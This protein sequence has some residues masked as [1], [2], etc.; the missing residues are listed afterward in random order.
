LKRIIPAGI[1]LVVLIAASV[2][3]AANTYTAQVQFSPNK[4]GT[5]KAPAAIGFTMNFKAGSSDA[6]R[7]AP[8]SDVTA[9]LYGLVSNG[10]DFPICTLN[11]IATAKSDTGCKKGS[12]VATGAITSVLGFVSQPTA[13]GT[14]CNPFLH[15]YNGGQGKL[16]FFFVDGAFGTPH[17]CLNGAITTGH[18]GPWTG[19]IKASGKWM[20]L[21]IKVPTFVTYPLGPTAVDGSLLTLNLNWFKMS[22][23]G[24]NVAYLQSVGCLNGKRPSS[25]TFTASFNGKTQ[26]DPVKGTPQRCTK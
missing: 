20:L 19:T 4:A 13:A 5:A 3:Y 17:Q 7:A 15:V 9:K 26:V 2:A 14:P 1:A 6:N 8:L 12:E 24:K 11:Q 25:I 22:N 21:D 10:K 18:V 23:K 16:V